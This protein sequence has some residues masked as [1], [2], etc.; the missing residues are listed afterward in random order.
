MNFSCT[1]DKY[2]ALYARWLVNPGR[3]LDQA[4]Y[5]SSMRLLDLCGGT[6]AVT[7]EALKRG[8]HPENICLFDLNPRFHGVPTIQGDVNDLRWGRGLSLERFNQKFDLIVCRQAIAYFDLWDCGP[9]LSVP[10]SLEL[11]LA[12]GGK[13]VFNVFVKPKWSMKTYKFNGRRFF[14]ASWVSGRQVYH[15]QASPGLG[16]DASRFFWYKEEE[17]KRVFG[18]Y[19]DIDIH[20][21]GPSQRWVCTRK[22]W[23]G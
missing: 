8:S 10:G 13:F 5:Q 12:P 15:I 2:D 16:L 19:F 3:L 4:G 6:G 14:E 9:L 18:L 1:T 7:K 11:L 17:L 22:S 20:R 23:L 21:D